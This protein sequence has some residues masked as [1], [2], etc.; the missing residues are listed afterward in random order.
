M[1]FMPR[2]LP[3]VQAFLYCLHPIPRHD[4]GDGLIMSRD[5]DSTFLRFFSQ[6]DLFDVGRPICIA[7]T[8]KPFLNVSAGRA[9][10][11]RPSHQQVQY[12]SFLVSNPA[13][14]LL[15]ISMS[16]G[17]PRCLHAVAELGIADALDEAPRTAEELAKDTGA[18]ADALTRTVS[19]LS[20]E[21]IFEARRDGTWGHSP[22]SRLLRSDHPQSMRS[23]VRM[24]GLSVYWRGF[25]YF[26]DVLRTGESLLVAT[27]DELPECTK[28]QREFGDLRKL[29]ELNLGY[30]IVACKKR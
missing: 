20:A 12:N 13:D 8:K 23:F 9:R 26:E 2:D 4:E 28:R 10:V 17:V 5:C 11:S 18:N 6:A 15:R 25:E 7:D 30:R 29:A 22:I 27:L 3:S 19:V 16:D 21:G 14:D 24:I 1:A